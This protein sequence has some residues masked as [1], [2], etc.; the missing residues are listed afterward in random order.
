[1]RVVRKADFD[2]AFKEGVSVREPA[3]KVAV[4]RNGL[5]TTTRLGVAV[6]RRT[7]RSSVERNRIKRRLRE[8]FRLE[9]AA[10]PPGLDVIA[11]PL[12][13][14]GKGEVPFARLRA[15]L[16]RMVRR[17][18]ERLRKRAPRPPPNAGEASPPAALGS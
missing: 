10:L 3:L 16:V 13:T 15:D 2:R 6:P 12:E 8:A 7:T 9:R 1:V 4:T 17:A 14:E 5:G 18:E 11:V